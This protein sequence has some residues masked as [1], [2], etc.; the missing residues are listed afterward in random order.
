V[1]FS[2]KD[3]HIGDKARITG[4]RSGDK[5]YRQ[6]LLAMGLT[7]GVEISLTKRAPLGDP[8]ELS[9]RGFRLSLRKD[10]ADVLEL[11]RLAD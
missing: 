10:E 1:N 3:M 6:K 8:V 11:E 7:T 5:S 2:L 9:V 4:Y